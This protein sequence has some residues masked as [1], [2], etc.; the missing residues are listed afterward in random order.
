MFEVGELDTMIVVLVQLDETM[1]GSWMGYLEMFPYSWISSAY[2]IGRLISS[3]E[4]EALSV[5]R[6]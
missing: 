1:D 5:N 3:A 6:D 2:S 4:A